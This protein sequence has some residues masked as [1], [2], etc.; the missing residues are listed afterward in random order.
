MENE[1]FVEE[2][3]V[4][5]AWGHA[6]KKVARVGKKE[7]APL[8]VAITGDKTEETLQEDPNIRQ[9]LDRLLGAQ[10]CQSVETVANTIFP[11]SLW[12]SA[13]PRSDLFERYET[14]VDRIRKANRQNQH[15]VYF[16]RMINNGP[17]SA[18][19]QLDFGLRTYSAR[20]GVRRSVLQVG[21]FLILDRTTR[22][23]PCAASPASSICR[24]SQLAQGA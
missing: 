24:S 13:R 3:G 17:A 1:H 23:L 16:D 5:L 7:L 2:V 14:I 10:G 19:N 4:S 12:N 22:R 6:L 15:G 18:E 9:A 11:Y 20:K 8:T 21:A